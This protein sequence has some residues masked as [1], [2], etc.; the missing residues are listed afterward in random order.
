[1][2][3]W[4][5]LKLTVDDGNVEFFEILKLDPQLTIIRNC[6]CDECIE[7]VEDDCGLH[8]SVVIQLSQV[9]D[10]ADSTLVKLGMVHLQTQANILNNAIHHLDRHLLLKEIETGHLYLSLALL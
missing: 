9:L 3:V 5:I 8:H 4:S 6:K 10:T 2:N 1:M 7:H